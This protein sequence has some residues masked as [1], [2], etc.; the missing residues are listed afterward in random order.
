MAAQQ[1]SVSHQTSREITIRTGCEAGCKKN[2]ETV[3]MSAAHLKSYPAIFFKG[4]E[5]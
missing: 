3:Q 1:A 5:S 2:G 4:V